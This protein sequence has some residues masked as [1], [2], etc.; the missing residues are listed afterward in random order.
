MIP[1][2]AIPTLAISLAALLFVAW[3]TTMSLQGSL[4]A[5]HS[6]PAAVI[7]ASASAD[8]G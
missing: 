1:L 2:R 7:A 8:R 6:P 3:M 4:Y 5:D